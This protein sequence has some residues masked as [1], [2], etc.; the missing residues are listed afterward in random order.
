[1]QDEKEKKSVE[2]IMFWVF[3]TSANL[4]FS[5]MNLDIMYFLSPSFTSAH[6]T[7]LN[8]TYSLIFVLFTVPELLNN[9]PKKYFFFSLQNKLSKI[10]SVF[11][12]FESIKRF[13]YEL[14]CH[15]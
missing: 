6:I 13:I 8:M 1:M 15:N 5:L 14:L 4:H 7:F 11:I 2:S 3:W 12:F 9:D 10:P